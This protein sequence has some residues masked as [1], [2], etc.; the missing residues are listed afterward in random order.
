MTTTTIKTEPGVRADV[1]DFGTSYFRDDHCDKHGPFENRAYVLNRPIATGQ[2]LRWI[3]CRQCNAEREAERKAERERREREERE[4]RWL[5]DRIAR[6]C[7]P[8]RLRDATL[9]TYVAM[10]PG[11]RHALEV[12]KGYTDDFRTTWEHGQSLL[13]LG[14]VG[15]GK[16]HIAVGI[17]REAMEQGFS[18]AFTTAADMLGKVKA[19]WGQRGGDSEAQVIERFASIA[20]LIIDEVGS[21]KCSGREREILFAILNSRHNEELPTVFTANLKP[22][23]LPGY[24]GDQ[25]VSRLRESGSQSVIFGWN[26]YRPIKG[27]QAMANRSVTND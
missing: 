17:A 8:H 21:I 15:T 24:L 16:T 14:N 2:P 3:G 26:D 22:D 1:D 20:L 7:I 12:A 11:Q 10:N 27:K 25:I 6:A 13:L 23:E 19:T 5:A 4:R 18:A 9:A